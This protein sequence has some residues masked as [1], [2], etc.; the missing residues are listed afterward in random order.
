MLLGLVLF[1][2]AALPFDRL[3]LT[4]ADLVGKAVGNEKNKRRDNPDNKPKPPVGGTDCKAECPGD[5]LRREPLGRFT[6]NKSGPK[7]SARSRTRQV[8]DRASRMLSR[9][10][11][12]VNR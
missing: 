4:F 2:G 8:W 9:R 6:L 5:P 12:K 3:L 11:R 10:H 7:N 1:V